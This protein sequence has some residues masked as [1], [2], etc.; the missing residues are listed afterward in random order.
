MT[1]IKT[2]NIYHDKNLYGFSFFVYVNIQ[3]VW[4][5]MSN[6]K[7]KVVYVFGVY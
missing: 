5:F 2:V 1:I 6:E 7:D 3:K 4:L